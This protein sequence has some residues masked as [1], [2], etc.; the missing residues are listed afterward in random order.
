MY[1]SVQFLLKQ[2]K[3]WLKNNSNIFNVINNKGE[4]Q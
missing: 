3:S 4:I 2:V 1:G